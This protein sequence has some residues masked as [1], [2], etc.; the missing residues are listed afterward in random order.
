MDCR[1][2]GP[3]ELADQMV[4][5]F[6]LSAGRLVGLANTQRWGNADIDTR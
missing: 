5:G 6:L 3:A 4:A 1:A 2:S